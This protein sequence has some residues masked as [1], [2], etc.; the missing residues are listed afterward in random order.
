MK[1]KYTYSK[2][3]LTIALI[4]NECNILKLKYKPP[5]T[6][7]SCIRCIVLRGQLR[8]PHNKSGTSLR[9]RRRKHITLIVPEIENLACSW[10]REQSLRP[11]HIKVFIFAL[12]KGKTLL[13]LCK[14][15]LWF[16][17]CQERERENFTVLGQDLHHRVDVNS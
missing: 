1:L 15:G 17:L 16:H 10:T 4:S 6:N 9:L 13:H 14:G 5:R 7:H 2:S 3:I 12:A 11:C 8:R